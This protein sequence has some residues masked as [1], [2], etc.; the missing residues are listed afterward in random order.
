[1]KIKELRREAE[2]MVKHF[3]VRQSFADNIVELAIKFA[4]G[5]TN[6]IV[7]FNNDVLETSK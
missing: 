3:G 6:D 5:A 7:G 1:M 2:S 4:Q